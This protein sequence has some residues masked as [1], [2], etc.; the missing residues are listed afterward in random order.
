MKHAEGSM[1][2]NEVVGGGGSER[3]NRRDEKI[4]K[5]VPGYAGI[6]KRD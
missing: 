2:R 5:H 3:S 6:D 1:G 4:S